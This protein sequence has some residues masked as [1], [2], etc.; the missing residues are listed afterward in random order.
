MA[1]VDGVEGAAHH[2]DPAA[3][4]ASGGTVGR[5]A[6][7][8]SAV[9]ASAAEGDQCAHEQPAGAAASRPPMT[10][11]CRADLRSRAA[12]AA[13][14]SSVATWPA[15][16]PG[17]SDRAAQRTWP[18][19]VTTYLVEVI[20]GS[21]IGPRAC[22]FW[23]L[24]PISA[25]NPNSPPSVNRV[26]R[27]DHDRG[28]VDLGGEPPRRGQVARSRSPRC[29][30]STSGGCARSRRRGRARRRAA[31]SRAR[32]SV[33]QSSSVAGTT[34]SYAANACVAVDGD[35]GVL[36]GRDHPRH[37]RVGDRRRAPAATRRR[38]RRWCA[39][40]WLLTTIVER[41]VEV[42]RA[43]DVD[44]AVADAGLDHRHGRLLDHRR[45]SGRLR[46]AG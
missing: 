7:A 19:P 17:P 36:Q 45:G 13:A 9:L 10:Q 44:V 46:R 34:P 25:P 43:V 38:C 23:V 41:H 5:R 4:A 18:S 42:G 30:R 35:P 15:A 31:M 21:P 26:R 14:I 12:S 16:L 11:W 40:S 24:M 22:S 3:P 37:E 27:V 8:C 6:R 2:A 20:S 28:G 29:D 32:Y 39:G 33:A 1:V